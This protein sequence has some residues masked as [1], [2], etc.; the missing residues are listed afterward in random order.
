MIW[1]DWLTTKIYQFVLCITIKTCC[2]P[3]FDLSVIDR[4]TVELFKFKQTKKS[5]NYFGR[6]LIEFHLNKIEMHRLNANSLFQVQLQ[7]KYQEYNNHQKTFWKHLFSMRVLN[8]EFYIS[9]VCNAIH[10]CSTLIS[11]RHNQNSCKRNQFK[12]Q[13]L[14]FK[15]NNLR[16]T[17]IDIEYYHWK[18]IL[19]KLKDNKKV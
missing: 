8:S 19:I 14:Q 5:C 13:K 2:W 15:D 12:I 1:F 9:K 16:I 11:F 18:T 7:L 4:C 6:L 17:K 10:P 3:A